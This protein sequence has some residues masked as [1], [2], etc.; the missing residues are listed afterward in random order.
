MLTH[1]EPNEDKSNKTE[2][3]EPNRN[4]QNQIELNRAK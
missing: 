2:Q 4:K 3:T 1:I